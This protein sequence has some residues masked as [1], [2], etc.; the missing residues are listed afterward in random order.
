MYQFVK[1]YGPIILMRAN[2]SIFITWINFRG[3]PT[4][5]LPMNCLALI[6]LVFSIYFRGIDLLLF[7]GI[8]TL[9]CI[10]K[11]KEVVANW[12]YVSFALLLLFCVVII[13]Q[14]QIAGY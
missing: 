1:Q 9:H 11:T 8:E 14:S 6:L 10:L 12:A 4:H 3:M 2:I 13:Y 5:L 7:L